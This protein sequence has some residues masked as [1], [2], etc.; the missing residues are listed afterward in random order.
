MKLYILYKNTNYS[1]KF[2][3]K[4]YSSC[5]IVLYKSFKLKTRLVKNTAVYVHRHSAFFWLSVLKSLFECKNDSFTFKIWIRV[6]QSFPINFLFIILFPIFFFFLNTEKI[7]NRS[8]QSIIKQNE[9]KKKKQ[10][11]STNSMPIEIFSIP[12]QTEL[13]IKSYSHFWKF[14]R[15]RNT[16]FITVFIARL[17]E[18]IIK[19]I[20]SFYV[21][22][23]IYLR[24]TIW[25]FKFLN[26]FMIID[27]IFRV[28]PN[29]NLD[30]K[31]FV[32]I[33]LF[34]MIKVNISLLF[35][36]YNKFKKKPLRIWKTILNDAYNLYYNF[37]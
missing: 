21:E 37:W 25:W 10:F 33:R 20:N 3:L 2:R 31:A 18:Q 12:H 1:Q 9:C 5:S 29:H 19:L 23:E 34:R 4:K 15:L 7:E 28:I 27:S 24:E 6:K 14:E 32:P 11:T 30:I 26:K 35:S 8:L 22:Y 16:V 36:I 13:I 17:S